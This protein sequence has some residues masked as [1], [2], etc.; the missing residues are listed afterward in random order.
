M[1]FFKNI[2]KLPFGAKTA[3]TEGGVKLLFIMRKY[4]K[5][6]SKDTN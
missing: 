5:K 2:N 6:P 1:G 3:I 4:R